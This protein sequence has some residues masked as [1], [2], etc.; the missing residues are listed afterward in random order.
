MVTMSISNIIGATFT[1]VASIVTIAAGVILDIS[2][3][4]LPLVVPIALSAYLW[5][6]VLYRRF[7]FESLT[8]ISTLEL[9]G[10]GFGF[11]VV[12]LTFFSGGVFLGLIGIF[13]GERAAVLFGAPIGF[14]IWGSIL[15][16][17]IPYLVG[18]ALGTWSAH[19]VFDRAHHTQSIQSHAKASAD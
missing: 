8:A 12:I 10:A 6:R 9:R 3:F 2:S 18:V 16:Y 13:T 11:A 17:G 5:S 15:T 19:F 4:V 1:V 7:Y 14:W